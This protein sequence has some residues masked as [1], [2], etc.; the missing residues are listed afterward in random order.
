M[1]KCSDLWVIP[2]HNFSLSNPITLAFFSREPTMHKN[3][4]SNPDFSSLGYLF[5]W[6]DVICSDPWKALE[7]DSCD[8]FYGLRPYM[9]SKRPNFLPAETWALAG[10]TKTC[11]CLWPLSS[12][13]WCRPTCMEYKLLCML[14]I[15]NPE[16][17][18]YF[19]NF[20]LQTRPFNRKE[21]PQISDTSPPRTSPGFTILSC[22]YFSTKATCD[23]L[24]WKI[25]TGEI[26]ISIK[27]LWVSNITTCNI[28]IA[29][30]DH[31]S[32][33]LSFHKWGH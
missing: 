25:R 3:K 2:N 19:W 7:L 13:T 15:P 17:R 31:S 24:W 28:T 1:S 4:E 18:V 11:S 9:P 30:D 29:F 5:M 33:L 14:C 23:L 27:V 32:Q 10:I 21:N 16:S 22:A 12:F 26:S 20:H 8:R 6:G